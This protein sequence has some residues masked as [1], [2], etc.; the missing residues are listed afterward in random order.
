AYLLD[1]YFIITHFNE[2]LFLKYIPEILVVTYGIINLVAS[3]LLENQF[4]KIQKSLFATG[5]KIN[6]AGE[7]AKGTG[8]IFDTLLLCPWYIWNL[9][10][11]RSF[12][13]FLTNSVEPIQFSFVGISLNRQ[14]IITIIRTSFSYAAILRNLKKSIY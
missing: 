4:L 6:R 7:R 12:L 2:D 14:L 13:L 8:R 5:W 1:I 11:R 3:I 9:K 10:I